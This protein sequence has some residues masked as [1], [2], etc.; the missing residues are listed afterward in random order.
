MSAPT[1]TLGIYENH[2]G[3]RY[4]VTG[5]RQNATNG[6][7]YVWGADYI[8]IGGEHHGQTYWREL[9]Q[10]NELVTWAD[11]TRQPRFMLVP[12]VW[13]FDAVE[14]SLAE[15]S[16]DLSLVA[17]LTQRLIEAAR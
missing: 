11:G 6:A 15:I 17:D 16:R 10:F 1:Q 2:K 9:S 3:G 12:P 14:P 8:G 4:L 7:D 13:P 5:L